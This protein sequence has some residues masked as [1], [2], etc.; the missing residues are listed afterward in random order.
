M[1][2]NILITCGHCGGTGKR[3]LTGIVADTLSLLVGLGA[4]KT[5]AE[6][7][8]LDKCKATAMNNRLAA[9]ERMGLITSRRYGRKRLYKPKKG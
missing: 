9:L 1:C 2:K 8:K 3:E 6:L 4:E 7:A 5:G